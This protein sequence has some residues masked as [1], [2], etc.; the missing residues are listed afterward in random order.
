[1]AASGAAAMA[2]LTPRE[3]EVLYLVAMGC[4]NKEIAARL[5]I[6]PQT[7]AHHLSSVYRSLGVQDGGNP[8]ILATVLWYR[9]AAR[10]VGV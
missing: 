8:R 2:S 10:F 5:G 1:M 3:R 6:A 9:H 7:V 4:A